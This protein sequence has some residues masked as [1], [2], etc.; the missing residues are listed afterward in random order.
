ML[1]YKDKTFCGFKECKNFGKNCDRSL[2]DEVK[3]E[4]RKFGLLISQFTD[5]PGCFEQKDA[6]LKPY[7]NNKPKRL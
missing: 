1:C 3:K 4:A 7:K 6:R 5:R 2:T